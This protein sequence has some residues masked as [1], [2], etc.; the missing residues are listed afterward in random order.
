MQR[1]GEENRDLAKGALLESLN[2]DL[3]SR[4]LSGIFA[5]IS[6]RHLLPIALQRDFA[7]VKEI[8]RTTFYRDLHK[9][10]LQNLTWHLFFQE[11]TLNE[12]HA[13]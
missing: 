5:E 13:L 11:T 8:L 7:S 9:G 12:H 10:N 1:P 2:R 3:T 4:S 6:Y